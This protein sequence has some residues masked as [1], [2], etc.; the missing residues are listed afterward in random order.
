MAYGTSYA[1]HRGTW[2]QEQ[3]AMINSAS[4]AELNS[5]T[6]D[7]DKNLNATIDNISSAY[8]GINIMKDTRKM[9][10]NPAVMQEYKTL[11]LEPII[12]E[13]KNYPATTNAEKVHLES[14]A[15][16]LETAWDSSVKCFMESYNVA[17]YLPLATLDFPALVKQYIKFIGKELIPVQTASSTN[18]EQRIFNKFLVN[19]QTGEEY[20]TPAIYWQ[21]DENG[22]PLWRKLFNAGKGYRFNPAVITLAEIQN[23]PNKKLDLLQAKY[24]MDE[25]GNTGSD[26]T[27][28]TKTP[29][30]RISYAFN[31]QYVQ[32]SLDATY[33]LLATEPTD[34]STAYTTYYQKNSGT[35]EYE[36]VP[37][38]SG[39]PT[40]AAN[41]YYKKTA[42]AQVVKV[43]L[44]KNGIQ[45]D[46]QTGGVFLNGGIT[47]DQKL[48]VVDAT[49]NRPTGATVSFSDR[50]SGLV[51]FVKGT[52]TASSCGIITGIY[53]NG[54]ISNETNLRT[55]GFREY[56]EI[57]KFLIEDGCRF[58]LSFTVEDFAEA[59]ASLNFNL[60]NRFV[61]ELINAQENFEDESIIEFLEDQ[62]NEWNGVDSNIFQ[63]DSYMCEEVA[64]L[65]P[66]SI[67][68]GFAGD[69]FEYRSNAI[70]NAI[71]TVI[72]NIC[73]KTKLDNIGF[74]IYC[75]PKCAR[76]LKKYTSWTVQKTTAI[77]GVQMN[78]SFGVV[79]DSDVPIRVVSSNRIN[80]YTL[81]DAYQA[82]VSE[83]DKSKEYIF[84]IVATP[85]DKFHISY[86]HLRFARHLTNS[87]ENAAY[88]DAT[89]P[90]GAA[91]NVTTSSMYKTI[92]IQGLQGRVVCRNSALAPDSE[93]GLV[94]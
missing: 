4:E 79:T 26:L 77:G 21:T 32:A 49:T 72:N 47:E 7:F 91:V 39:A 87:P 81:V 59:N 76:F 86:K 62:W 90:G 80:A 54:Y 67:S 31:I 63:L 55:I 75:N 85:M 53:V 92:A 37:A 10:E 3:A 20:E 27:S 74:V 6:D 66:V 17:N 40:F 48:P 9:M 38:G 5:L 89:N 30:T 16:E 65:S 56:P 60:Y 35:G 41:T 33:E 28:F 88:Q 23:A 61:Q 64:D 1:Q 19:N 13:F 45:V 51:D 78:Y 50:L 18:I 12:D 73:D 42:D 11:F 24:L 68:P 93:A 44:P 22:E 34:W 2:F 29:R 84:K 82:D 70:Y 46:V 43:K 71:E 69:P 58:Q 36:L 25:N 94:K 14:V 83:G 57:R 52:V 8:R 15:N